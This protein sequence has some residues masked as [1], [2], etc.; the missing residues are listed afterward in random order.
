MVD[1]SGCSENEMHWY[2]E[3][4]ALRFY[5]GDDAGFFKIKGSHFQLDGFVWLEGI[6]Q[7]GIFFSAGGRARPFHWGSL[8][9]K[10][11][12]SSRFS[13]MVPVVEIGAS[14]MDS[15]LVNC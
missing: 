9:W 10:V 8:T 5:A 11:M 13:R 6:A 1:V 12:L 2:R 7:V 15:L 4:F 14:F 3:K